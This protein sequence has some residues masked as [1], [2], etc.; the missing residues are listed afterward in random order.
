MGSGASIVSSGARGPC[1]RRRGRTRV[2]ASP[3][4]VRSRSRRRRRA[5]VRWRT[6]RWRREPGVRVRASTVRRRWSR[7]RRREP[8]VRVRVSIV[9]SDRSASGLRARVARRRRGRGR[10]GR[11]GSPRRPRCPPCRRLL[12]GARRRLRPR[13]P[14][15]HRLVRGCGG[16]GGSGR[17]RLGLCFRRA[18]DSLRA[19]LRWGARLGERTRRGSR[20]SR[21]D[22]VRGSCRLGGRVA[23]GRGRVPAR[24]GRACPPREHPGDE[25]RAICQRRTDDPADALEQMGGPSGQREEPAPQRVCVRSCEGRSFALRGPHRAR[26]RQRF[27]RR[28]E[29]SVG[30]ELGQR[31][32]TYPDDS[33]RWSSASA[34]RA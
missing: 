29:R 23:P 5:P 22:R 27:Q 17:C 13:G 7:V 3:E 30:G 33:R 34:A 26:P 4:P 20:L 12:P 9:R 15:G 21:G 10:D 28:P 8:G 19:T 6:G 1:G 11:R 18:P 16:A 31:R 32:A 24:V 14:G 2:P 25:R